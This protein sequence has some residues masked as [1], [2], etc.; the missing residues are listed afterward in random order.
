MIGRIILGFLIIMVGEYSPAQAGDSTGDSLVVSIMEHSGIKS[1]L[2]E[3][4]SSLQEDLEKTILII[5]V[6]RSIR[7]AFLDSYHADSLYR[8]MQ[9]FIKGRQNA[10]QLNLVYEW[11]QSSPGKKIVGWQVRSVSSEAFEQK[12]KIAA[13]FYLQQT[14]DERLSLFRKLD[15]ATS[16]SEN[17]RIVYESFFK[18]LLGRIDSLLTLK[19]KEKKQE[20]VRYLY[21]EQ[22]KFQSSNKK[23]ISADYIYTYRT[24]SDQ[25]IRQFLTF[26]ISPAGQWYYRLLSDALGAA[27]NAALDRV[28]LNIKKAGSAIQ[29]DLQGIL[30]EKVGYQVDDGTD[31]QG[32]TELHFAAADGD[33]DKINALLKFGGVDVDVRNTKGRTPLYEAAKLGKYG[34]VEVLVRKGANVNIQEGIYGFTPLHVAV[35]KKRLGIVEFLLTYGADVNARSDYGWTPLSQAAWQVWHNDAAVAEL[36]LNHGADIEVKNI[37]G[38]TPL[39]TA[40][41]YGHMPFVALLL[42]RGANVN[43]RTNDGYTALHAAAYKGGYDIVKMLLEHGA[44]VNA[45]Y[46]G[47]TPLYYANRYG[48]KKIADLLRQYGGSDPETK[49]RA[50]THV[51]VEL[52]HRG[53]YE[54]ALLEFDRAI[55]TGVPSAQDYYNRGYCYF[56]LGR[57]N[58]A[59]EDMKRA[60]YQDH[61]FADAYDIMCSI[62]IQMQ[63]Y[64]DAIECARKLIQLNPTKGVGYYLRAY[65]R[66][67]KGDTA[68]A[69]EDLQRAC[70]LGYSN[71]CEMLKNLTDH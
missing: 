44:N 63:N 29:Y 62:N 61:D 22:Q 51:G 65:A 59:A 69:I 19:E 7:K 34:S 57:I 24:L 1:T 36:L 45:M 16:S 48:Y 53:D 70:D 54:S 26:C 68:G 15:A 28:S 41:D 43:A 9:K 25:E 6:F 42:E 13:S 11:Y 10:H 39:I 52:S 30:N 60:I 21:L 49:S 33:T 67:R 46:D 66:N 64:D 31:R 5:P 71:G 14:T 37:S 18:T 3:Y 23:F 35:E 12:N 20:F 47:M 2:Q 58:E 50:L 17:R 40:V 55:K 8:D 27:I 38:F 32:W 56:K 4:H